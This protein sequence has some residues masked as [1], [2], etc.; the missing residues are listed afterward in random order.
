VLVMVGLGEWV[1][2]N[3]DTSTANKPNEL[4]KRRKQQCNYKIH[5]FIFSLT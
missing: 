1:G 2:A 4:N 5:R 3:L